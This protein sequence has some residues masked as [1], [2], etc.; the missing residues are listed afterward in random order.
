M[1]SGGIRPNAGRRSTFTYYIKGEK[2]TSAEKAGEANG[3]SCTAIRKW[4]DD[5]RKKDCFRRKVSKKPMRTGG[6]GKKIPKEIEDQAEAA[7]MTAL[8]YLRGIMN[9]SG[10]SQKERMTAAYWILPYENA[11]PVAG[12]SK[13]KKQEA[14]ER[15]NKAG[16]GRF[17]PS[18]P[19]K[20]KAV[21]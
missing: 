14:E 21:K 18:Q 2:Y 20:L 8:E 10:Q 13:S 11:K 12:S 4:C 16:G 7:G 15:A 6:K 3:V 5:K 19:P 17:A 1:P 9:D